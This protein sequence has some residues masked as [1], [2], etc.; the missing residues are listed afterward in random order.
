MSQL[1]VLK[2]GKG[3]WQLGFPNVV[4][5][6][7]EGSNTPPM[8]LT[9]SLPPAPELP[10]LYQ[11]WRSLYKALYQQTSW[12][13]QTS[14]LSIEFE[15][16]ELTNVSESDFKQLC[17]QLKQDLNTWLACESFS[18]LERRL[19]TTL[20]PSEEIRLVI[21]TDNERLRRFPWHLWSF[22]EDYPQ[23]EVALSTQEYLRPSLRQIPG[24]VRILAILGNSAGINVQQDRALLKQLPQTEIL[25]LVEPDR[26]ELNQR[27]WEERGW[28]ILFFAGHS[29][30]QADGTTG[31]I[32][33]NTTDSL[34]IS[35]LKHALQAAIARGLKLA[36]FNSCD[37]LGL[38]RAL[39]EL[40]IPLLI[41]M[42]EPVPD[43]V[44][45][46]FLKHFLAAFSRGKSFYLAVREAREKLQ[47]LENEFPCATWLS[48]ICQNPAVEPPTWSELCNS[49]FPRVNLKASIALFLLII[50][51]SCLAAWMLI[52]EFRGFFS[53]DLPQQEQYDN[54]I[55]E[56]PR[57]GIKIKYPQDWQLR[58]EEEPISGTIARFLPKR[59]ELENFQTE[60]IV[61]VEYLTRS[62]SLAEYTASSIAE[63]T[64]YF[65]EAKILDSRSATLAKRRAHL[66][67]YSGKDKQNNFKLKSMQVWMLK[68]NR[69]YIITYMAEE[70]RYA[71]FLQPVQEIMINSFEVD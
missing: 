31:Q 20:A 2:L 41:V 61:N 39:A 38:A 5:Q 64:K 14:R 30:S 23:A 22:F 48:V 12:H 25:F 27:L 4:A 34:T 35:E 28:D 33:L 52:P 65:P 67:I 13:R 57:Y 66:V 10:E 1:V 32:E 46:E 42:R 29:S 8:Q 26:R 49:I 63:I 58:Q 53:L 44:A 56:H 71:E 17:K 47:G 21:E 15:E 3:N 37:G 59:S 68:N 19:R 24:Q 50:I 45:Q 9:G 69:A 55:Y 70:K 60:L 6:I 51:P 11:R 40:H 54:L 7:V 43:L 36:I 18:Q 62:M 16:D